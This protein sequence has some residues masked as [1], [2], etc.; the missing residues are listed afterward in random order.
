MKI[1]LVQLAYLGDVV[2]TTPV[3]EAALEKHPGAELWLLVT[4]A[5]RALL[6]HDPRIAGILTFDKRGADR[7]CAGMVRTARRLK[8]Q[9]FDLAY[10][11]HRS[12]R[13]A[14]LLR[15]AGIPRRVGFRRALTRPLFTTTV[16]RSRATH[17]VVR[18]LSLL[19]DE[20]SAA[21]RSV[22]LFAPECDRVNGFE[23]SQGRYVVLV[24]GSAWYTKRWHAAGF[25]EVAEHFQSLGFRVV[26]SGAANE[27]E[28]CASVSRGLPVTDVSG[29][30]SLQEL[31]ALIKRASLVVCNDSM[32]LHV[33]SAFSVPTV[34]I[35]CATSPQFGFG[36]WRNPRAR[37][38]EKQ[39]LWCK[40][41]KRHGGRYCPTGTEI[42]IRDVRASEVIRASGEVLL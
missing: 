30:V 35:F 10:S 16:T 32:A 40:P 39:G 13:T 8:T 33:A 1:L 42:C 22:K 36:P 15:L 20:V 26:V 12:V 27:R 11:I 38:V 28:V 31:L 18:N 29:S 2:L 25:R 41:C 14:L 5:A 34:A 7:G 6:Q 9:R 19:E 23:L 21:K 37:I 24:P 4:P 3:I 17:D